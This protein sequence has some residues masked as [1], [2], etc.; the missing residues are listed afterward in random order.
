MIRGEKKGKKKSNTAHLSIHVFQAGHGYFLGA[1]VECRFHAGDSTCWRLRQSLAGGKK[2]K[3]KIL[4]RFSS[5][6]EAFSFIDESRQAESYAFCKICRC[7]FNI[8]HMRKRQSIPGTF[9][10]KIS[11]YKHRR[12][13]LAFRGLQTSAPSQPRLV[14]SA[15]FQDI[16]SL[17]RR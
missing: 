2:I 1:C 8:S 17:V 11:S 5:K 16:A 13:A 7:D 12:S 6:Y 9:P 10:L 4:Q 14:L 15:S 3:K